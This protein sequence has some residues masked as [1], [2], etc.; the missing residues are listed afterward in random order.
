MN[1]GSKNQRSAK[2]QFTSR[3]LL[4][5]PVQKPTKRRRR[6]VRLFIPLDS[7]NQLRISLRRFKTNKQRRSRRYKQVVLPFKFLSFKEIA[8][9]KVRRPHSGK[10][11][12]KQKQPILWLPRRAVAV[13]LIIAIS[14]NSAA[15]LNLYLDRS[16]PSRPVANSPALVSSTQNQQKIAQLPK[17]MSRSEPTNLRIPTISLDTSLV[18]IGL[19]ADKTIQ[20]LTRFDVA[21]WYNGGPTPGELGPAVI[22]GHVDS[23]KGIAVFF[24]LRELK[25]GDAIQIDRADGSTANFK[26]TDIKKFVR[27]DFP[28]QGVYG[29]IN[30]AGIRLITCGGTFNTQ[31]HEY[32]QNTVVYGALQ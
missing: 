14:I 13:I 6:V 19:Q 30:Y 7:S 15:F 22:V 27:D 31:T 28:T 25:P 1:S 16:K 26:V 21:A 2:K 12:L 23:W 10:R 18:P 20:P 29:N 11:Y 8:T 9:A 3:K 32:D 17:V 5:A 24:R 4:L